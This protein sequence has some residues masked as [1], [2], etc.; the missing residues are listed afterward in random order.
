[1]A[2]GDLAGSAANSVVM[3]KVLSH[4]KQ[5]C[6]NASIRLRLH[7]IHYGLDPKQCNEEESVQPLATPESRERNFGHDGKGFEQIHGNLVVVHGTKFR[8]RLLS[9]TL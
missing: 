6:N 9:R 7:D 3:R 8:I 2:E 5:S 1:L 4:P